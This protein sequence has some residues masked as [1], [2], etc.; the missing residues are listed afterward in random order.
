MHNLYDNQFT[1]IDKL[2]DPKRNIQKN[3]LP[4]DY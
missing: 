4:W 3:N 2:F 1:N